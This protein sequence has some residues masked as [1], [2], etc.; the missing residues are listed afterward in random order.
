MDFCVVSDA[1][2]RPLAPLLQSRLLRQSG[3]ADII[4]AVVMGETVG[5]MGAEEA[6]R[7]GRCG[8]RGSSLNNSVEASFT[9]A[10]SFPDER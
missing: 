4:E 7:P 8:V 10:G 5:R 1:E 9:E 6:D 2:V 3:V